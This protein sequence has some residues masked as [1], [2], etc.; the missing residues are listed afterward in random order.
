MS[1]E[2]K[3]HDQDG[4]ACTL[5]TMCM[6]EPAWAANRIRVSEATVETWKSIAK[7]A[8]AEL[9]DLRACEREAQF[10]GAM[11]EIARLTK[12]LDESAEETRGAW[13]V[14]AALYEKLTGRP[15]IGAA[16]RGEGEDNG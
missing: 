15:L 8:E 16:G 13:S 9:A 11:K 1:E 2:R 3:Y 14:I 10:E 4:N 5:D 6:R 7:Q 12:L